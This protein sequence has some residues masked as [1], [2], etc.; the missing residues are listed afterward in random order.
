MRIALVDSGIG[1][2]STA[3]ALRE[4]RPDADLI[5]SMD[6]DHMPWGP[7]SAAE[8]GQRA[9]A[10]AQTAMRDSPDAV[11]VACNTA[12]VHALTILRAELE[13][14]IP[15]IGTVP[16]VKPAADRGGPIAI[17][18]TP[19]T[20]GSPYQRELVERFAHGVPVAPVACHGLAEAVDT[21]DPGAVH[22]AIARATERTPVETSAVV[23]GCTHYDLVSEHIGAA[24]GHRPAL[25]TAAGAVAAQTLRRLNSS[26][27][28]QAP[29]TGTL[30]V[31]AS[32]R[33]ATLPPAALVYPAGALLARSP[34][35]TGR[36]AGASSG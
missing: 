29:H 20:T 21:A 6:P 13:P 25:L 5:L 18:A 32:G 33:L 11:V 4:A 30:T 35:A 9:L 26:A 8:I 36:Q 22:D 16:A 19:A 23:L 34:N 1:L 3:A 28:P 14:G 15:V 7:R 24:L 17:W 31:Y 27:R 10:G 12:S 2:L